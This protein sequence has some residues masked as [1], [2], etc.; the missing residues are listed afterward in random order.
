MTLHEAI[1][2][3]LKKTGQPMSARE[4]AD[5]L[6]K[7]KWY[8]K[9]DKSDIKSS[10]ISARVNDHDDIFL[11]N[12][13]VSPMLI[14]L[15]DKNS[16]EFLS[17]NNE[18]T[19]NK[20][21]ESP[22]ILS[23]YSDIVQYIEKLK[24]SFGF[25]CIS[26]EQFYVQLINNFDSGNIEMEIVSDF[27]IPE[28]KT[29]KNLMKNMH[30]KRKPQGNFVKS[31]V[32]N[33]NIVLT[34]LTEIRQIFNVVFELEFSDYSIE[35]D[36]NVIIETPSSNLI[37]SK[38]RKGTRNTENFI[39]SKKNRINYFWVAVIIIGI[40]YYFSPT[41]E[42]KAEEGKL[43]SEACIISQN[44]V[45]ERLL[46]KKSADFGSC[47]DSKVKYLGNNR[48][49]IKNSVDASNAFGVMLSQYYLVVIKY[50]SGDWANSNNWT[51]ESLE[52][53]K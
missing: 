8:V 25:L 21:D 5:E 15:L 34:C 19:N 45:E 30:F 51:L 39:L 50:E 48:Y 33:E 13:S 36:L 28:M 29:K 42:K 23:E 17:E 3:L 41:D 11:I 12:K 31:I 38:E 10:Q 49:Q 53:Y 52:F 18:P 24:C 4:I 1:E 37:K 32:L 47:N 20:I 46:S 9:E 27:Y 26:K 22:I 7:N 6:N 35:S 16:K 44:F 14:T 40:F 2:M 43:K